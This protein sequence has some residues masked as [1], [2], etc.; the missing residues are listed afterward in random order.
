MPIHVCSFGS[1]KAG[2][3]TVIVNASL[4]GLER[5]GSSLELELELELELA[6]E[7]AL[8]LALDFMESL[9]DMPLEVAGSSKSVLLLDCSSGHG[10]DGF[11][12]FVVPLR[13]D[14]CGVVDNRGNAWVVQSVGVCVA[15]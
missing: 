4:Q 6:L 10:F 11:D 2:V 5:I 8:A 1:K 13:E 9:V 12:G 15:A 14:K 3:R 7:L